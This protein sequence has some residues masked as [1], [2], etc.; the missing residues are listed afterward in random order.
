MN[1]NKV[2]MESSGRKTCFTIDGVRLQHTRSY[3]I[4]RA[5]GARRTTLEIVFDCDLECKASDQEVVE[6]IEDD[7]FAK[8][9]SK[10]LSGQKKDAS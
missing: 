3:S 4:R 8:T 7:A 10:L 2:E 6:P 9:V 1:A 5:V